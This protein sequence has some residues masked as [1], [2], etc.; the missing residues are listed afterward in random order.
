MD[1]KPA[2]EGGRGG[3]YGTSLGA[4][5]RIALSAGYK[6]PRGE[7]GLV[8]TEDVNV[9]VLVPLDLQIRAVGV[10]VPRTYGWMV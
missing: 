7:D 3:G 2:G 1:G 8:L 9:F 6:M 4:S 5:L 10:A